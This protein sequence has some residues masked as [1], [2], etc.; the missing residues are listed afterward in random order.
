LTCAALLVTQLM[1]A[2][3]SATRVKTWATVFRF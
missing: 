3:E 2:I 1:A